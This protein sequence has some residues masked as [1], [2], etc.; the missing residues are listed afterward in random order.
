MGSAKLYFFGTNFF[1]KFLI[2]PEKKLLI[3][4]KI[5]FQSLKIN[6]FVVIF[7]V[8]HSHGKKISKAKILRK[9][10]LHFLNSKVKKFKKRKFFKNS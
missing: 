9:F 4:E 8:T 3:D 5:N 1:S 7:F 10:I 6:F 2:F